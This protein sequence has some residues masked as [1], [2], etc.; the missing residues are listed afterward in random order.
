MDTERN[1]GEQPIQKLMERHAL[2]PKDIVDASEEQMTH[3]MVSRAAKGRRL[4]RN[5]REK[6]LRALNLASGESYAM[7]DLFTYGTKP[8]AEAENGAGDDG[9]TVAESGGEE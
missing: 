2:K 4:T 9:A 8:K 5:T 6:V 1:L 7:G 3:K